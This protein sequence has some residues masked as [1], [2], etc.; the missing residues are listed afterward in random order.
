[1]HHSPDDTARVEALAGAVHIGG[2]LDALGVEYAGAWFGSAAFGFAYPAAKQAAWLVEHAVLPPGG[3]VPVDGF[4]RREV[5]RQVTPGD[6]RSVDVQ[7]CVHEAAQVVHGRTPKPARLRGLGS[8]P[9][10]ARGVASFRVLRVRV[11][12]AALRAAP[13]A[14]RPGTA[15][16]DLGIRQVASGFL[17]AIRSGPSAAATANATLHPGC[18]RRRPSNRPARAANRAISNNI[19][20]TVLAVAVAKVHGTTKRHRSWANPCALAVIPSAVQNLGSP[21]VQQQTFAS[22]AEP[23]P[24]ECLQRCSQEQ[25]WAR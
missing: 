7:N 1:M 23:C 9:V 24:P 22:A 13:S 18:P 10:P 25:E 11:D 8:N 14:C 19:V 4:P 12:Q 20:Q 21:S 17:Q 16:Q 6:A 3:E 5:V 2:G 15:P